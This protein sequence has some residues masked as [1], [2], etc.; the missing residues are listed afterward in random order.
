MSTSILTETIIQ[1][2]LSAGYVPIE[3]PFSVASVTFEFTGAFRGP[4]ARGLDLVLLLDTSIGN[5]DETDGERVRNR[6]EALGRALDISGSK[7]AMTAIFSGAPFAGL[8]MERISDVCRVLHVNE[9][10]IDGDFSSFQLTEIDDQIRSL[11][12]LALGSGGSCLL[13]TSPSPRD[14]TRS[15]MPSSA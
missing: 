9:S 2:L 7:F 15:R 13:Y 12:P 10:A 8:I 4:V 5:Y 1:K 3:M 14:R 6:I 11:L